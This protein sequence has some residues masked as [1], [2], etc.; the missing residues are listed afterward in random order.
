MKT[1]QTYLH[2]RALFLSALFVCLYSFSFSQQQ[3]ELVHSD[4]FVSAS[5]FP[6]AGKLKGNVHFRTGNKNMY[7]DSAYFHKTENWIRAYSRVQ[8]NQAD[9]LNLFCDSLYF[10]G[11]TNLGI[12][13]G[14]VRFRDNEFKM[15]TDSLE[16]DANQSIG[17]YTN[18]AIINSINQDLNLTSKEGYYYAN[19]KTFFFKDSVEVNHPNYHL[20]ADT[21]EFNTN[22]QTVY[23][24]GPTIITFDSTI[25]YC[26]KGFYDT[27]NEKLNLWEGATIYQNHSTT[28]YAD[29]LIYNQAT[30]VAYG[31]QNVSIYDSTQNVQLKS[32]YLFKAEGNHQITLA[33]NARIYKYT[34]KDTLIL[35]ADTIFQQVD[36]ISDLTTNIAIHHVEIYQGEIVGVCD[37]IYFSEND[38]IIKMR[39]EPMI[40]REL[41]QLSADSIDA[42]LI[43]DEIDKLQLFNHAFITTQHDSIHYD[44]ISGKYINAYLDSSKIK[45]VEVTDLAQTIYYPIDNQKD[46]LGNEVKTLMGKNHLLAEYITIHFIN[47]EIQRIK[48]IKQAEA[49]FFPIDQI[50]EKELYLSNFKWKIERKPLGVIPK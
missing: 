48:F 43:N 3:I 9:T 35:K 26:R 16:F 25:V 10:D 13:R 2:F 29:S 28:I 38:S 1:N 15:T 12:L 5:K 24:H 37:S 27:Q 7:C 32:N 33:N 8:I 49:S 45:K 20:T 17:Y 22:T 42:V 39:K 21:L 18:W 11:N 31:Y 40:W 6:G 4:E 23:F 36:S 19:S 47:S 14:N 44:Q 30:D 46:S 41:T 34:Q 50:P